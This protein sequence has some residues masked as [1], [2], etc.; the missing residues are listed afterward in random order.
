MI[1]SLIVIRLGS[2]DNNLVCGRITLFVGWGGQ[3]SGPQNIYPRI[4]HNQV[5]VSWHVGTFKEA[6]SVQQVKS[7]PVGVWS[8]R[9]ANPIHRY[10]HRKW[11]SPISNFIPFYA[12]VIFLALWDKVNQ[13][14]SLCNLR[15]YID[16]N[17][18]ENR[19]WSSFCSFKA[20]L[21]ATICEEL[22]L[23]ADIP[24]EALL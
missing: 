14:G 22:G 4:L 18:L 24:H 3:H 20:H 8:S 17:L 6:R 7:T 13:L 21:I 1:S 9:L 23:D 10:S 11:K 15:D 16:R 2:V 5:F 19:Q 12:R